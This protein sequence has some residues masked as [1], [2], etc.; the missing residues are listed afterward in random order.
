MAAHEVLRMRSCRAGCQHSPT[1]NQTQPSATSHNTTECNTT[2]GDATQHKTPSLGTKPGNE[3][4]FPPFSRQLLL[5][6]TL[7]P[8]Q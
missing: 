7:R 3:V 8:H 6:P 5:T 4:P 1:K 2:Q